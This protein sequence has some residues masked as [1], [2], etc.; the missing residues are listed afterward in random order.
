MSVH[1]VHADEQGR[2]AVVTVLLQEGEGCEQRFS[3]SLTYAHFFVNKEGTV[4]V[5]SPFLH[6]V[7]KGFPSITIH[8]ITR[9]HPPAHRVSSHLY[10]CL[11]GFVVTDKS[12][13]S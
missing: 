5:F 7:H 9:S 4:G 6:F 11:A 3:N 10:L 2:L 12:P 8:H 1:P 13:P